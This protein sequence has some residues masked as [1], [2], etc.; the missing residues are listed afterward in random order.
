MLVKIQ[1]FLNLRAVFTK[2]ACDDEISRVLKL[3]CDD[4]QTALF[5]KK[6]KFLKHFVKILSKFKFEKVTIHKTILEFKFFA[7]CEKKFRKIFKIV[8]KNS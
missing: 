3:A 7:L 2:T 6:P 4:T 1:L 5:H 8:M